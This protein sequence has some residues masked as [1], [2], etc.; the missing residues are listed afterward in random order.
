MDRQITYLGALIPNATLLGAEKAAM[1]AQAFGMRAILGGATAIHG[2][3]CAPTSPTSLMVTVGAGSIYS[4]QPV[5]STAFGDLGTDSHTIMKQGLLQDPVSLT[6]S[7]PS[8]S[9][10]SQTYLVQ[11]VYSDVDG[12]SRTLPYYNAS[13]PSE[14]F[15]GP[16]NSGIS[17][18]TV[19]LGV[20]SVALKAGAAAATGSQL[21]PAPDAG[22]VGLYAITV[23]NA[24]TTIAS[25]NIVV[26]PGA[27]FIPVS[28]PN[29]PLGVQAGQWVFGSA[30]STNTYT[31]TLNPIPSVLT[32]DM[33]ILVYIA[34]V[35]TSAATTLNVNGLGTKAIV[36]QNGTAVVSGDLSGFVPLILDN[37]GT[38]WRV[39]GFVKS[40][41]LALVANSGGGIIEV[42]DTGTADALTG[43]SSVPAIG[44]LQPGQIFLVTKGAAGNA[45]TTPTF[46]VPLSGGGAATA[47]TITR[48]DTTAV[49]AADLPPLAA[50]LLLYDGTQM[51]HIG[52]LASEIVAAI[53]GSQIGIQNQLPAITTAGTY[54]YTPSSPKVRAILVRGQA[55]GGGAGGSSNTTSASFSAGVPGSGG[56][57]FELYLTSGFS[58]ASY[59]VGAAGTAGPA[60]SG[61]GGTGGTTSWGGIASATGGAG[62][63]TSPAT[64]TGNSGNTAAPPGGGSTGGNVTNIY[65]GAALASLYLNTVA[66]GGA[67]GPSQLGKSGQ[68]FA[69]TTAGSAG[70]G[71]GS[72]GTPGV[73]QV[74]GSGQI[75]G[76]GAGGL[77][78]IVEYF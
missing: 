12:G 8:T 57:Y 51:R 34:N 29:V 3:V 55:G 48:R 17:Q 31:T 27:P 37:S 5:D 69:I 75:G 40:D 1:V 56:G 60:I 59:T 58:G 63:P 61:S 21:T 32:A 53:S 2:L 74:S 67:G 22:Y 44:L 7:P 70:V 54:T 30:S 24:Q 49:A 47:K 42:T 33:E 28:L 38:S 23:A 25:A 16:A 62:G 35:N 10:Y 78:Q 73:T 77:I 9:G 19:R 76:A 68:Q 65:G 41:I 6:I 26:V 66:F 52:T 36:R 11:A 14:P 45:T 43:T 13:N 64:A 39:N 18:Y 15:A 20:C 50:L 71:F 72:G 4:L 46:A